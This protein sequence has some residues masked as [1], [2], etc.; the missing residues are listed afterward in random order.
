[1]TDTNDLEAFRVELAALIN[2]HSLEN[3]SDTPDYI[4]AE[5]LCGCLWSYELAVNK[6][7]A[8]RE[9]KLPDHPTVGG[10]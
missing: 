7:S 10:E 8:W 9:T 6:R 4:L 1:M 5:Y 3:R 2:R